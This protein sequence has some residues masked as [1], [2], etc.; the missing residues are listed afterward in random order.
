VKQFKTKED[1]LKKIK[2]LI[3]ILETN[4]DHIGFDIYSLIEEVKAAVEFLKK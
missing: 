1:A 3:T 2:K 4:D